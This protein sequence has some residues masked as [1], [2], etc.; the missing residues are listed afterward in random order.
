[1][2]WIKLL[3]ELGVVYRSSDVDKFIE[4]NFDILTKLIDAYITSRYGLAFW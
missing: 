2:I 1:M 4:E 3:K